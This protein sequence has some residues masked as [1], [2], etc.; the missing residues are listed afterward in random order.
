MSFTSQ[1]VLIVTSWSLNRTCHKFWNLS[2]GRAYNVFHCGFDW[3]F[4]HFWDWTAFLY[5]NSILTNIFQ[6]NAS[7]VFNKFLAPLDWLICL[8]K[9]VMLT[10][11]FPIYPFSTPWKHQ[12][13]LRG[14]KK[15]ALEKMGKVLPGI[16][17]L[18]LL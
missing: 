16:W 17:V 8:H 18:R 6:Q 15:S 9:E 10:H 12:K 4:L 3:P 5:F 1:N 13:I 7:L 11:L 14:Q 2:G